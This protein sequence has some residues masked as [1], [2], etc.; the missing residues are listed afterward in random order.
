MSL[1]EATVTW[2][3]HTCVEYRMRYRVRHRMRRRMQYIYRI[4]YRMRYRMRFCMLKKNI[5]L[6]HA[7]LQFRMLTC[8]IVCW[9]TISY[10]DLRHRYRMLTYDIV[11]RIYECRRSTYYTVCLP[12][13]SYNLRWRMY[14]FAYIFGPMISYAIG[15]P[16]GLWNRRSLHTHR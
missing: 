12:T 14:D 10:Y 1:V 7:N 16:L 13:A 5:R 9:H 15:F 4:R 2:S 6:S 8:V 3:K 11:G